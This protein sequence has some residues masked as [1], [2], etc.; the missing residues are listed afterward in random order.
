MDPPISPFCMILTQ[1]EVSLFISSSLCLVL[2]DPF[3]QDA[4]WAEDQDEHQY[5][6][7]DGIF[8]LGWRGDAQPGKEQVWPN[9]FKQTQDDRSKKSTRNVPNASQNGCRKG[10]DPGEKSHVK[11]NYREQERI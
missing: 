5:D 3:A 10:F 7:S 2:G 8:Q 4:C 6:E 1:Y 11:S 9:R